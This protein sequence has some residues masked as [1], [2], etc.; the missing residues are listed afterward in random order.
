M[1][2][3]EY[4]QSGNMPTNPFKVRLLKRRAAHFCLIEGKLYKRVLLMPLLRCLTSYEAEYAVHEIHEG[5]YDTH[6][7]GKTL[8]YK[9][10]RQG[11]YWSQMIEDDQNYIKK[12]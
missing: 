12:C 8:A 4:L 3:I 6:I 2:L 5:V 7:D 9:L 11:Y 1:P 10:L